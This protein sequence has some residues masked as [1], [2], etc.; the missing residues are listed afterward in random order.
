ETLREL[1]KVKFGLTR[2]LTNEETEEYLA[3]VNGVPS[4][5]VAG[6]IIPK[7]RILELF[8]EGKISIAEKE[9]G[10][11]VA[12]LISSIDSHLES[13]KRYVTG[14]TYMTDKNKV[15]IVI[16]P[17]APMVDFDLARQIR[18]RYERDIK[19]DLIEKEEKL[20]KE[21]M[22]VKEFMGLYGEEKSIPDLIKIVRG[23]LDP[24]GISAFVALELKGAMFN[25]YKKPGEN[26]VSG[27]TIDIL[28]DKE[29]LRKTAPI[30]KK[31]PGG[32]FYDVYG[33][34]ELGIIIKD[35]ISLDTINE[36][37]VMA[38]FLKQSTYSKGLSIMQERLGGM[39][40]LTVEIGDLQLNTEA[41]ARQ[42]NL[43]IAQLDY[44]D[45]KDILSYRLEPMFY[46]EL[47]EYEE[48]AKEWVD[49][50]VEFI[51]ESWRRGVFIADP[52]FSNFAIKDNALVLIDFNF[53]EDDT[54]VED[55]EGIKT[56]FALFIREN[57]WALSRFPALTGR[58]M[59]YFL[60]RVEDIIDVEHEEVRFNFN[61]GKFYSYWQ[62]G[63]PVPMFS[64][65]E[66]LTVEST[67]RDIITGRQ[68][69]SSVHEEL[70]NLRKRH[71]VMSVA[72]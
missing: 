20:Y 16:L 19:G 66:K 32:N 23:L 38:R 68:D 42:C 62:E 4:V 33:N 37:R 11:K 57:Y 39:A 14:I 15:E 70:T 54:Q 30:F 5:D 25:I 56:Q 24:R 48:E 6:G 72:Q 67:L 46:S 44:F 50:Y 17:V 51:K 65:E 28:K 52:K 69:F 1:F 61:E 18:D 12:V 64:E 60:E 31:V 2:F 58:V 59:K 10:T 27:K 34:E 71:T 41:G 47:N 13:G 35:Q 22:T 7:D 55:F 8:Q 3:E 26:L 45:E 40:A 43:S 49:K 63:N 29:G 53:L 9:D 36:D 21:V